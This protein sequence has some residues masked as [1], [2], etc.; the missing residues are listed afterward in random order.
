MRRI[1]RGMPVGIWVLLGILALAA[2]MLTLAQSNAETRPSAGSAAPSGLRIFAT[3]ARSAGF[4]LDST[5]DPLPRFD[6]RDV[7]VVVLI[8]T[9]SV[10]DW[11]AEFEQSEEEKAF[12]EHVLTFVREG[13]TAIVGRLSG[14]FRKASI[15]ARKRTRAVAADGK[16]SAEVSVPT[17]LPDLWVSDKSL[18]SRVWQTE[19]GAPYLDVASVGKGRLIVLYDW[20]PATNRFITEA[21]HA[22]ILLGALQKLT[23]PDSRLRFLEAA[24]GN[25]QE[26]G[27]LDR[28][29]P[30]YA[31][32]WGQI[33]VCLIVVAYSLGRGFGLAP[34]VRPRQRGQRDLVEATAGF[35]RRANATDVALKAALADARHK[36]LSELKL[37]RGTEWAVWSERV[38]EPLRHIYRE[39]ELASQ[40]RIRPQD[41]IRVAMDLDREVTA[42]IGK[43]RIASRRKVRSDGT[44][45]S[46]F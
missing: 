31:A 40:E 38:P 6:Q 29:G 34:L 43:E 32:G 25:V 45:R 28:L 26:P 33:I 13:G 21:D 42:F 9:A 27:I 2:T 44:R 16:T 12:E 10:S 24:W 11:I 18:I 14:N 7:P 46:R 5:R 17:V 23:P 22:P 20:L 19:G 30:G 36:I 4:D 8:E 39:V 37:A 15:D 41:A 1:V 35:Y 3:L